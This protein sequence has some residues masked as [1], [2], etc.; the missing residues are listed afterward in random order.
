M[1]RV[2]ISREMLLW[3]QKRSR[4][5]EY[6]LRLRFPKLADWESGEVQPTLKQL[7]RFAR[8]TATPVGYFFLPEPP[9]E[10][11]PIPDFR[12]MESPAQTCLKR[13]TFV[14]NARRGIRTMPR[15]VG[16]RS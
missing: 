4:A 3:A 14:S 16:Y 12:V 10:R 11:I 1:T 15:L 5:D 9:E 13:S 7:E 2:A 6:G 8:A